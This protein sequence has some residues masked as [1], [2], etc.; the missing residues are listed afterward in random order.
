MSKWTTLV[1]AMLLGWGATSA[2]AQG[3]RLSRFELWT[4]DSAP[5]TTG[6]L[7][8]G[9]VFGTAAAFGAGTLVYQLAGG[10]TI[11]G[12]D[13]CG[14]V[15]GVVMALVVEPIVVPLGVHLANHRRG[16]YAATLFASAAATGA[17]L[18]GGSQLGMD[19]ELWI[20]APIV[21]IAAAVLAERA[22]SH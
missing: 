12:D 16:N 8:M 4:P 6:R 11:C 17:V 7:V 20:V 1:L 10:G 5:A 9:G 3:P 15:A 13:P 14:L 21:Q 2:A 22:T 18:F 19:R